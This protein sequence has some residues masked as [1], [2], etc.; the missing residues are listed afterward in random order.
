MS[1]TYASSPSA[2]A[3]HDLV[4]AL[5]A[6]F[7]E[8][9][10][11]V[12]AER[13]EP[14][15]GPITWL[16]DGGRHGGGTRWATGDTSVFDRASVNVSQVHYDDLPAKPLASATALSTIIHPR[17]PRAPS[18][19]VHI[20][21][22][23]LKSGSGG[24][25]LMADLNPAIADEDD[26]ARFVAALEAASGALFAEGL[27]QG[28]RY[29]W[30]PALERHRG[31]A[32][33]YVEGLSTGDLTADLATARQFGET[34]LDA[35]VGIL[36]DALRRHRAPDAQERAL[37]LAYHTLYFLQVLTLDRGTTS[38][39]LVHSDNDV[40][41]LGSIPSHVDR[42]RL[43]SWRARLPAPQDRLLDALIAALPQ[44]DPA[45][46]TEAAKVALAA[47]SRAHYTAHPEAL[48]LQARG[49]LVPPTVDNHGGPR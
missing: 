38:G 9:L 34:V 28:D 43:Q 42:A 3:A 35:Y 21:W 30:I 19:H 15:F 13:E 1:R 16:R 22:T 41:T 17:H 11:H 23:E 26:T 25:R 2:V 14:S 31:V 4:E 10:S 33:F 29:F 24:W 37:Q 18:V 36:G 32:H 40:G 48:A 47:V 8:G 12:Q 49:D 44:G 39:L 20:S 27:R 45:P 5:Q 6:R 46:V 7:V